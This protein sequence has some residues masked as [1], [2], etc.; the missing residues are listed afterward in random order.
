MIELL[1]SWNWSRRHVSVDSFKKAACINNCT[2]VAPVIDGLD[3][4]ALRLSDVCF[5][6]GDAKCLASD[7]AAFE[8]WGIPHDVYAVNRS[9]L[10]FGRPVR[11]WAAID[12]EEAGWY[13]EYWSNQTHPEQTAKHTI[14][15]CSG[16]DVYWRRDPVM[17]DPNMLDFWIG[18]SGYFA[19]LTALYMGYKKIIVGGMPIDRT[20]HFYDP[21]GAEGP[22]W[23]GGAYTQWMD[24]KTQVPE[25][26]RVRSMSGYSAFILGKADK[27]WAS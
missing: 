16:F 14:G 2:K 5:I 27:E 26:D 13:Y 25:A 4:G 21:E 1:K 24:F 11:H 7:I 20:P 15:T 17:S 3:V 6:T 19:I 10:M 18:S 22:N 9:I 23:M 8:A 12:N